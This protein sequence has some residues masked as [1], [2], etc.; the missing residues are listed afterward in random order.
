MVDV[1]I[2]YKRED[3]AEAQ[4]LAETIAA[5]GY[6][7]WW[8]IDLLP[9][10]RFADEIKA[11]IEKAKAAVV[12]WSERSVKSDFVQAE[13]RLALR[14]GILLQICLDSA[15]LPLP[16]NN[17]NYLD[18][19]EWDR[20]P[21]DPRLDRLLAAI[22]KRTKQEPVEIGDHSKVRSIL[23]KPADEG[24]FWRHIT[25]AK[26]RSAAEYRAYLDRFGENAE[27]AEIAR[28]R[29]DQLDRT[30]RRKWVTITGAAA[31]II[32]V[33]AV[34]ARV[35]MPNDGATSNPIPECE[36]LT[37]LAVG[38]T[39]GRPSAFAYTPGCGDELDYRGSYALRVQH[40]GATSVSFHYHSDIE[41]RQG[42]AYD[43]VKQGTVA[44]DYAVFQMPY[45]PPGASPDHVFWYA[46]LSNAAG[47]TTTP[48][49]RFI[50]K[51]KTAT[52]T[53][54]PAELVEPPK[55]PLPSSPPP[56]P[57]I[58]PNEIAER[59]FRELDRELR[60]HTL[61]DM[62][63]VIRA[64][65]DD[66]V[67]AASER[68]SSI[69]DESARP[70]VDADGKRAIEEAGKTA[71]DAAGQAS[72]A[73]GLRDVQAAISRAASDAMKQ[74]RE[75][76][77]PRLEA[78]ERLGETEWNPD[79]FERS[80]R[81][82]IAGD[83]DSL[84]TFVRQEANQV[85]DHALEAATQS[86]LDKQRQAISEAATAEKEQAEARRA[87]ARRRQQLE[88]ERIKRA[89]KERSEAEQRRI[90]EQ[91]KA[92]AERLRQVEEARKERQRVLSA[93]RFE[94]GYE[95]VT[96]GNNMLVDSIEHCASECVRRGC[97]SFSYY[98]QAESDGRHYCYFH[99]DG[100]KQGNPSLIFG[101]RR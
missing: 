62:T 25:Q 68:N 79:A 21:R 33:A 57:K 69:A 65:I 92:E 31:A 63:A 29:I 23:A 41:W 94:D 83:R 55:P 54:P 38:G 100:R 10:D 4:A 67:R 35:L 74:E 78:A 97:M 20:A 98:K 28:I 26:L 66:L 16:F 49:M 39:G 88:A 81:D 95:G 47:D 34:I 15:D 5:K 44:G 84:K 64:Q 12:L 48:L 13:A 70:G 93:F 1:F 18:L 82:A 60:D 85:R 72:L 53:A 101:T 59:A 3:R 22:A 56:A 51:G 50:V 11:I 43:K 40:K 32:A 90:D 76:L 99:A 61:R 37:H 52:P 42:L 73:V 96:F 17:L 8:D 80:L 46:V 87:E 14:R 71:V 6:E 9:G 30:P 27:F 75:A 7:V 19:R 89:A 86:I 91:K 2:S 45:D 24:A 58:R 77:R 36:K